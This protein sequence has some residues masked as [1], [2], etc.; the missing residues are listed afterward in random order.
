MKDEAFALTT[1]DDVI[2]KLTELA[3]KQAE[4][5]Q[6]IADRINELELKIDALK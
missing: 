4:L 5:L 2:D 1:I 3:V 6:I